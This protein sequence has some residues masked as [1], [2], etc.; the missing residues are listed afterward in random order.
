MAAFVIIVVLDS[1]GHC[2][3][4][5]RVVASIGVRMGR[6]FRSCWDDSYCCFSLFEVQLSINSNSKNEG[7]YHRGMAIEVSGLVVLA[8]D[9][10]NAAACICERGA[11][12]GMLGNSCCSLFDE[13]VLW[14]LWYRVQL[15]ILG[16]G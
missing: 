15:R 1:H 4:R 12:F 5:G 11:V 3:G 10:T 6:V 8:A 9:N 2:Y 16:H 7:S 14:L 13:L